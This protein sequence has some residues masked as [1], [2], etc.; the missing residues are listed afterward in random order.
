[1]KASLPRLKPGTVPLRVPRRAAAP[2]DA[3]R[4]GAGW[5][6]VGGAVAGLGLATLAFAP[7]A[8]LAR[9]VD[10]ASGGRILLAEADG[11]LWSGSALPVLTGGPGSKDAAVLPSRLG[12]SLR[13]F[14]GGLRLS[15]N[16]E[17]C[18]AP[19]LQVELRPGLKQW[20]VA[21]LPPAETVGQWP[22][23]WLE[24][25]GAPWNTLKP[26][27]QLRIAT[28]Q[29]ELVSGAAGW[30]MSG[31]ADL[32]LLRASSRLSTLDPLGTYRVRLSGQPAGATQLNLSTLDGALLL[33]GNGQLGQKGGLRFRGDARAAPGA[34]AAL[35]NLLNIIGR[36]QGAQSVISIG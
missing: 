27:G 6:A 34:E 10:S 18:I 22:A 17:C 19:G 15:L 33:N 3:A 2:G 30:Q 9:A 20:R 32:E 21:V 26:G 5:W 23:G 31:Q 8:W 36:R 7:A 35:N 14:W 28:R 12:W 25:L 29:L 11:T 4:R 1:M 13:P 16:Q 24:G